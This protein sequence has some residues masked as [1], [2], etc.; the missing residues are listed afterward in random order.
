MQRMMITVTA[1]ATGAVLLAGC[2]GDDGGSSDGSSGGGSKNMP[3]M[4]GMDEDSDDSQ[5]AASEVVVDGKYSDTRFASMMAAHHTMAI[6]MAKVALDRAQHPELRKAAQKTIDSQG[7]EIKQLQAINERL[8]GDELQTE[9]SDENMQNS[10]MLMPDQLARAAPFDLA[11]IDSMTPHHAGAIQ[12]AAVA[13]QRSSDDEVRALARKVIDAQTREIGDM[14]AWR[15][16]WYPG[17]LGA[18]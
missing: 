14:A 3:T 6:E 1:L 17:K 15:R 11:F 2:G 8:G 7:A 10:G 13:L 5:E 18:S 4:A 9:M 16:S 12:M